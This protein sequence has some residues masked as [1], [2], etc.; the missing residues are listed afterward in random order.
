MW[1]L[2]NMSLKHP[3]P[4]L[5][6]W[7]KTSSGDFPCT[8]ADPLPVVVESQII[9]ADIYTPARWDESGAAINGY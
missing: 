8:E 3:C 9:N 4:P 6:E 7:M 2:T 1:L 5:Y